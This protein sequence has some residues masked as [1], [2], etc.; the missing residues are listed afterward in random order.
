MS[1]R[2]SNTQKG[3]RQRTI[4]NGL[5][6][7]ESQVST[8]YE[9]TKHETL[10]L[11][12]NSNL[13]WGTQALYRI[14][15]RGVCLHDINIS[16]DIGSITGLTGG[17]ARL[18]S[19]NGFFQ[20]AEIKINGLVKQTLYPLANHLIN[21]LFFSDDDRNLTNNLSNHY[22]SPTLRTLNGAT[23]TT[24]I[25]PLVSMFN[26]TNMPIQTTSHEVEIILYLNPLSEVLV[27]NGATG[28]GSV[29]ILASSVVSKITRMSPSISESR[30][31]NM[32]IVS[33]N[34]IYHDVLPQQYNVSTGLTRTQL[35][36]SHLAQKKVCFFMIVVRDA[37]KVIGDG[38]HSY[39]KIQ[40]F[41]ITDA[42][43]NHITGGLEVTESVSKFLS[44]Y[45]A[46]STYTSET[47][48]SAGRNGVIQDTGANVAM[49]SHS[50]NFSKAFSVGKMNGSRT[51]EGNESVYVTFKNALTT[52]TVVDVLA[53]CESVM[54]QGPFGVEVSL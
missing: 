28:V 51:Y 42:R 31:T 39:N 36:L 13:N 10:T 16:M 12:T 46:D 37:N 44:Q 11:A 41:I 33:E 54:T 7:V 17:P 20:R 53:F 21:Q 3:L 40:S 48:S 2:S 9:D 6:L 23:S 14:Q 18:C 30:L 15:E 25:I 1:Q 5:N 52:P 19:S 29:P 26:A 43:T 50:S 24:Y 8:L 22:A 45:Y 27:L 32:G 4:S 34:S 49:F 47:A 38:L 35:I